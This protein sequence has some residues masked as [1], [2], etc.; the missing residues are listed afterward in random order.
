[1][2]DATAELREA[3]AVVPWPKP[4]CCMGDDGCVCPAQERALRGWMRSDPMLPSMSE[5]QREWCLREIDQVEGHYRVD[6][7]GISS[8]EELARGVLNAWTD[9]CRDKGLML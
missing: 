7:E 6:Y 3:I 2:T 9:Y 1:M 4:R 8:D 5:V